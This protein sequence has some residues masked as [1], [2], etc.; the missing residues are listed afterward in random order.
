[1]NEY[2]VKYRTYIF[3]DRAD[4]FEECVE[5]VSAKSHKD[6]QSE[7]WKFFPG[8]ISIIDIELVD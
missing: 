1:M 4:A 6:A 7:F 3:D 8:L 5:I 2:K